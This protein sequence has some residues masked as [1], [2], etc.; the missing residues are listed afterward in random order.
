MDVVV[1]IVVV[2]VCGDGSVGEQTLRMNAH[3]S[4]LKQSPNLHA[5]ERKLRGGSLTFKIAFGRQDYSSTVGPW[6]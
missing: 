4:T 3:P 5:D 2:E 6:Q 1:G